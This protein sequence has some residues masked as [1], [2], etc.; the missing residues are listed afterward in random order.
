MLKIAVSA[1]KAAGLLAR[2]H[3]KKKYTIRH[4]GTYD[5]VTDIDYQCESLI[6]EKIERKYPTHSILSEERGL[7]DKKSDTLWIIDPLD[8]TINYAHGISYFGVSIGII[9]KGIPTIG[10]VYD[11]LHNELIY[12][13]KGKG[14]FLNHKRVS[15]STT[16]HLSEAILATDF[17]TKKEFLT[18]QEQINH[19]VS[20]KIMGLRMMNA[21]S[22]NMLNLATGRFDGY[23]KVTILSQ[24]WS[25]LLKQE[26]E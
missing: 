22:L 2:K 16:N 8:G 7:I 1:C 20:S 13:E 6:I 4:K 15:V 23:L 11:A 12:A 24:A 5:L 14:T 25:L 17:T 10:V 21:N 3:F 19:A 18:K 26:V 9:H